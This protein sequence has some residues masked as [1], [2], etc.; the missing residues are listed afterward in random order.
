MR[1]MRIGL[2]I[3]IV[4]GLGLESGAWAA[5]D[6]LYDHLGGKAGIQKVVNDF[7]GSVAADKRINHFFAHTNIPAFKRKLVDQ[8][9]EASGGP[10][11]TPGRT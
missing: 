8:I 6:K 10:C 9:C 2:A 5:G 4:L 7:V 3:G 11:N 1:T